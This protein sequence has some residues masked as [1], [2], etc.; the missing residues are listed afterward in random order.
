MT[1]REVAYMR[2]VPTKKLENNR[3]FLGGYS[4]SYDINGVEVSRTENT[5]N[6]SIG[7][8]FSE[9]ATTMLNLYGCSNAEVCT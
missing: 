2:L 8:D 6:G 9:D 3:I 1:D 5:W 7:C 4:I